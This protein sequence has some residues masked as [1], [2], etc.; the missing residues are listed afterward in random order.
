MIQRLFI[1]IDSAEPERALLVLT[2]ARLS[3]E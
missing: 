2:D 1:L 3:A